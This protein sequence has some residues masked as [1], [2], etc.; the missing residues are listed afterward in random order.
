MSAFDEG[1]RIRVIDIEV[2]PDRVFKL[3]CRAMRA[4]SN[5]FP[6]ERSKPTFHLIEPRCGRRRE[7]DM[8]AWVPSVFD[9]RRL[10][11]AVVVHHQMYFQIRRHA[12]INR[13]Q[14]LQEFAAAMA[15]MQ[16]A[17]HLT[18]RDVER[19]MSTPLGNAGGQRQH[20]L[21]AAQCL[22]LALLIQRTTP[23]P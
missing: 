1:P 21:R 3:P 23:S 16:L 8:E 18:G 17:D 12:G 7:V 15:P 6:G 20:G 4:T 5:V 19:S 13:A 9:R 2:M 22:D 11:R 10:M 14:E